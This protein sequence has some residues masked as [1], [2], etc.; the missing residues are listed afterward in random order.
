[1]QKKS[2]DFA[3]VTFLP[4]KSIIEHLKILATRAKSC[5]PEIVEISLFGSIARGDYSRYSDGD[6]LVILSGDK[7]ERMMERIPYYLKLFLD[8][9][10]PVDVLPYTQ[11]ELKHMLQEDNLFIQKILKERLILA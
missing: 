5:N 9:P 6:L 10:V 1:M 2:S 8:A 7:R 3:N 4:R 11:K